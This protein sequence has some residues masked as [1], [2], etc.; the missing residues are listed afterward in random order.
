VADGIVADRSP[1]N[2]AF[3]RL[4]A[5]ELTKAAAR[6]AGFDLGKQPTFATAANVSGVRTRSLV[7]SRR[8]DSLTIF[9]RDEHYG[10]GR[11]AGAWTGANKDLV[12]RARKIL[13]AAKVPDAEIRRI[14]IVTERGGVAERLPSGEVR[15]ERPEVLRKLARAERRATGIPVWSSHAV[16]GL[17]AKGAV[18]QLEIHWPYIPPPVLAEA[19]VLASIAR[20]GFKPMEVRGAEVETVEAGIIHSP[21]IG[22]VMD[23]VPA[24]RCI[25]R[26]RDTRLGKKPVLYLDR[27]G[28]LVSHPRGIEPAP[29]VEAGRQR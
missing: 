19:K 26:P 5:P 23:V 13:R 4:E 7:F 11:K 14:R 21:A 18:G 15:V 2:R 20:K 12:A 22:F 10:H 8:L 25:Y 28:E 1:T 6:I 17:T 9:A 16:I 24:I 27:H 29:A 3:A